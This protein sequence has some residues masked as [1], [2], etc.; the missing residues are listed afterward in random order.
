[1]EKF[2]EISPCLYLLCL[3]H[4]IH[5]AVLD[6]IYQKKSNFFPDDETESSSAS[7]SDSGRSISETNESSDDNEDETG[8]FQTFKTVMKDVVNRMRAIVKMFRDS[9][10]KNEILQKIVK[11]TKNKELNLILDVKT[12]WSS[13]QKSGIRFLEIEEC[14]TESLAHKSISKMEMW[15]DEDSRLLKVDYQK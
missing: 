12:R 3:N 8:N 13:F 10:K 4:G 11:R 15:S 1:M 5:L 9:P 7:C 2:G 6:V 14:V